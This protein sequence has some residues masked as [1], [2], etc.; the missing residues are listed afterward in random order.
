MARAVRH[1]LS[2]HPLVR[3]HDPA[4]R[5]EGGDGVTIAHLAT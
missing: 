1:A 5:E 2:L 3:S 4:P